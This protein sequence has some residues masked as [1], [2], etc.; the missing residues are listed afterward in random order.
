MAA[1]TTILDISMILF[2]IYKSPQY[3]LSSFESTGLSVKEKK[4]K[5]EFQDGDCGG[6]IGFLIGTISAI[7][8]LKV[9]S[10]N[11]QVSWHFGTLA[12]VYQVSSRLAS[13]FKR[14]N[15]ARVF[16]VAAILQIAL[17]C[18]TKFWV[19][20]P[21]GLGEETQNRFSRWW[22]S[23]I[24]DP[25]DCSYFYT[26]PHNS[27]GVSKPRHTIVAGFLNPATI[28]KPRHTIVAGYYG[29]MLDV[30]VSVRP[31]YVRFSFPDDNFSKHQLISTKLDMHWH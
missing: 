23:W 10:T 6:P 2:L 8:D 21:F 5:I 7:F 25:N 17:I 20:G 31:S 11:F 13:W 1:R 15:S 26:P 28:V 16:K 14:R 29:F 3:F 12:P 22:Q 24:S 9:H 19:N 4:F 30:R 18:P 27:G